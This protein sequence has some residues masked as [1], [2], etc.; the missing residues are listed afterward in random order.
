MI[1]KIMATAKDHMA[2]SLEAF[3][4]E[5]AKHRTGRA[6][7]ALIEHVKIKIDGHVS[8]L[9]QIASISILDAHTLSVKPWEKIHLKAI[10]KG[11]R[12]AD[13]GLNP[14]SVGESVLVPLPQLTEE[15]RK[16]L[17]KIAKGVAEDFRVAVRNS[18][19]D[20]KKHIKQ[21]LK[22][23]EIS[24]GEEKKAENDLQKMTDETIRSIDKL[25][26][27]KEAELLNLKK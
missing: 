21:L 19:Q 6:Q 7:P 10:D 13:L 11:I 22:D 17:V 18:R 25:F 16:D 4:N 8:P 20:A 14:S 2:K 27:E 3:K 23:K 15:R 5:L 9:N 12:E 26:S 24:E 1:Q